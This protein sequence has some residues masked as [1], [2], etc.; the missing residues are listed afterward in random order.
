MI[1]HLKSFAKEIIRESFNPITITQAIIIHAAQWLACPSSLLSIPQSIT[2][3][4]GHRVLAT[5]TQQF[6]SAPQQL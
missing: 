2:L 6:P 1:S 4:F 3:P 5:D